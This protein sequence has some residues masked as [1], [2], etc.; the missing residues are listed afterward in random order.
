MPSVW[1]ALRRGE[2]ARARRLELERA[3]ELFLSDR[4]AISGDPD[5]R[6]RFTERTG[7]RPVVF[8][9]WLR[10]G[11]GAIDP[12]RVPDGPALTAEQVLEERARQPIGRVI[13]TLERL[14]LEQA[15]DSGFI[16]A[17]GDASGRLLWVDGDRQLRSA[18]EDMGFM[19]G[20]DWSESAVGTSA[21][22][23]AL[24]LD[25]AIQVLGAEH[26]NRFVHQWS[27]TASPI[28]DPITG[29]IIGV[30]DV[31][32]GDEVAAP[33]IM[34]MVDATLAAI[35]AELRLETIRS[36][37]E[38]RERATSRRATRSR[39]S[40][41][42]PDAASSGDPEPRLGEQSRLMLLGRDPAVLEVGHTQHALSG[43]HAEILLALA[44]APR[45]LSADELA[46]EV[47][48][49]GGSGQTLR[50]E[51][52]R[53]RRW[54]QEA[55]IPIHLESRP[56]R[57][58]SEPSERRAPKAP[59]AVDAAEVLSALARGAHRVALAAYEGPALPASEAPIVQGLRREVDGTLREAM[60]QGAAP[61]G[62]YAYAQQWAPEDIEVWQT[63][64]KVLPRLS[65]RRARI[66]AR[67]ETLATDEP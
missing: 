35:S 34:P 47:Y 29:S 13:P 10:A 40:G 18:A 20:M 56:Y 27:C 41:A 64:L 6:R 19:A 58:T 23:S 37:M 38:S 42:T 14:L 24:E 44:L 5:S 52:V 26:F 25:H 15:R 62:L 50:P 2:S 43:R 7:V 22:G 61:D 16:I 51:I 49:A 31:T 9:S 12:D 48:G 63:L 39:A 60:L 28:R 53:L 17:V 59:L 11:D 57:L 67:L 55:E 46:A 54:L 36:E 30:I 1:Q 8:D 45:G 4:L 66:V 33:H 21:P 65:P 32:G 3:H